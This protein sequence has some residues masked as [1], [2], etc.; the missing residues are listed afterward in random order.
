MPKE[1]RE[2]AEYELSRLKSSNSSDGNNIRNYL[3]WIVALPWNKSTKDSF[4]IE[5]ASMILDEEHY[6]L[7]EVKERILE[8]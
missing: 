1:V 3:D 2:K 7:E 6:G 4:N 8:Y 5:K